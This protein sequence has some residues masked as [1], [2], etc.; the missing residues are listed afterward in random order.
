LAKVAWTDDVGH[1]GMKSTLA[2]IYTLTGFTAMAFE[3]IYFLMQR[4]GYITR[5]CILTAF[6]ELLGAT[7]TQKGRYYIGFFQLAIG[8]ERAEKLTIILNHMVENQLN[9]P[10]SNCTRKYN[11]DLLMLYENSKSIALIRPISRGIC[12]E[13]K[14]LHRRMLN[15]LTA[16]AN[17]ARYANLDALASGKGPEAEPL[18]E[19]NAIIWEIFKEDVPEEV[20]T[21]MLQEAAARVSLMEGRAVVMVHDLEDRPLSVGTMVLQELLFK[22]VS[23]YVL[24]NWV[25]LISPITELVSRLAAECQRLSAAM[26]NSDMVIPHMDEFYEFLCLDQE[27]VL[28][29]ESWS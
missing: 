1:S 2:S 23:P 24:W 12:F 14:P 26:G 19:W 18:A 7:V 10:G 25:V 8:I 13:L 29:R 27:A 6:D 20:K 15:F 16:F 3:T 28:S 22:T 5:S 21:K 11:H 17:G 4:E 9:T